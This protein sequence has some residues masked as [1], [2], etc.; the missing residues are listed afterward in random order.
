MFSLE[1][2]FNPMVL[3]WIEFVVVKIGLIVRRHHSY[4]ALHDERISSSLKL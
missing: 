3:K 1:S 4:V 2:M